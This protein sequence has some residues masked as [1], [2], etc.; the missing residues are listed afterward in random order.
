LGEENHAIEKM[1]I[2]S[3]EREREREYLGLEKR[4]RTAKTCGCHMHVCQERTGLKR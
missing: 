1:K 4:R 3:I 2:Q